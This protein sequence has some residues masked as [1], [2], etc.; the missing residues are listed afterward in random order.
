VIKAINL[1][2]AEPKIEKPAMALVVIR[3]A[4]AV[5]YFCN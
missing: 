2:I 3:K 1:R 5:D 4:S